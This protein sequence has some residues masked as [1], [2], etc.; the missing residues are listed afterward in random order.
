[1]ISKTKGIALIAL[2]VLVGSAIL[3][4]CG[5]AGPTGNIKGPYMIYFYAKW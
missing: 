1:M 5:G 4:A 3:S 2:L